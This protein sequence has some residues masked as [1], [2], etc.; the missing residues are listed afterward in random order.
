MWAQSSADGARLEVITQGPVRSRQIDNWIDRVLIGGPGFNQFSACFVS[1]VG[2][3]FGG[4]KDLSIVTFEL[5]PQSKYD[6]T[7][8]RLGRAHIL[9][10][11]K[12]CLRTY[13][14]FDGTIY[15]QVQGTPMGLLISGFIAEAVLQRLESLVFQHYKPKLWAQ[16]VD[17]TFVVIERDQV[18]TFKE[19]LNAVF[20]YI[21]FTMEEEESNQPAFLDVLSLKCFRDGPFLPDARHRSVVELSYHVLKSPSATE[22]LNNFPECIA[23]HRVEGFHQVHEGIV[24]VDSHFLATPLQLVSGEDQVAGTAM[25]LKVTLALR[26]K[27]LPETFEEDASEVLSGDI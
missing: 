9:Q 27:F 16:Y 24:E 8:N 26:R 5:L 2:D 17:D 22:F 4:C 3:Y 15:E 10:L 21:Q 7:E 20:P 25:A 13:F 6:E 14:T 1:G 11:R 23:M 18:L 12:L 19:R